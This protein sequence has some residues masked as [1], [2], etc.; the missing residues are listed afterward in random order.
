METNHA[1]RRGRQ[2]DDERDGIMSED[3]STQT[4]TPEISGP[5]TLDGLPDSKRSL[6]LVD[7]DAPLGQRLARAMERRRLNHPPA[8]SVPPRTAAPP[9]HPPSL[10][11]VQHRLPH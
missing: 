11:L 4:T 10:A 9:P 6:L 5:S 3:T 2:T 1:R 7:D 8:G